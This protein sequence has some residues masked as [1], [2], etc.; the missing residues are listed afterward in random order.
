MREY[1]V[2][3]PNAGQVRLAVGDQIYDMT[4]D[5]GGWWGASAPDGDYGFLLDDDPTVLPDPRS[6]CQ[7]DGVHGR[8]RSLVATNWTDHQWRGA[9]VEGGVIYE[10]HIGTFTPEG[11]LDAAAD[12]LD[13]LRSIGV[14]HVELMPVNAFNGVHNWGYDGVCWYAVHEEYGGPAA[15]QRFVDACHA[16]GLA[17][18]QDVVYNHFGPSGNYLPR[19]GPYLSSEG[20]SSWGEHV[21][22]AESEVRRYILDNVAFWVEEMHVDALRL[23]AVHA[24]VDEPPHKILAEMSQLVDEIETRTGRAIELIAESDLNDPAMITPRPVG[25]GIDAQWSDD[26]HHALHVALTRE[27]DGYYADFAGIEAMRKVLA[28][29]FFHDGTYSSF[30]GRDHGAPI[31][32]ATTGAWRL[33]VSAQ[34]HDQIGN[35]ARGDR[36]TE[37]LDESELLIAALMLYAGPFTPMLFMGEE[38]AASSPFQY[39]TSHPEADLGAAVARGRIS[40]FARMGWDHDLVPNPQDPQTFQRSKLDW[41]ECGFRGTAHRELAQGARHRRVLNAYRELAE[42]RAELP[43]LRSREFARDAWCDPEQNRLRFTR[44]EGAESA[45]VLVNFGVT[46]WRVEVAGRRTRFATHPDTRELADT[47]VLPPRAG[48]L[49]L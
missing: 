34:N 20:R 21:N 2:W 11:T 8:S 19:F 3:A 18:V 44:A 49:L 28:G 33:V 29:G 40:E 30:R 7:P 13:H 27:T 42:L 45:E 24:L 5:T 6:R 39:F 31:D 32:P 38:W 48:A 16:Q 10:L 9:R 12:R 23:D 15:Y 1:W 25:L 41:S 36:I 17:V 47:I 14:T 22:L 43:S 26:F 35:R 46:E 37:K 4:V